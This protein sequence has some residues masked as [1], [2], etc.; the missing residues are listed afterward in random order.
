MRKAVHTATSAHRVERAMQPPTRVR[1]RPP[2]TAQSIGRRAHRAAATNDSRVSA[3]ARAAAD[4]R[5]VGWERAEC[6]R[7][8]RA[9]RPAATRTASS[10]RAR[11]SP[12]G[13]A[14]TAFASAWFGTSR[15][16]SS[17]SAPSRV[18]GHLVVVVRAVDEVH[19][20][21]RLLPVEAVVHVAV[22]VREPREEHGERR[23]PR[24]A[25]RDH[26]AEDSGSRRS[27]YPCRPEP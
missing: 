4:G 20:S 19:G 24:P 5:S 7:S 26:A 1:S 21:R 15:S 18:A 6:R 2:S 10:R 8:R 17:C 12:A 14:C 3:A 13:R 16:R 22:G 11:R 25:F 9:R 27:G 23:E